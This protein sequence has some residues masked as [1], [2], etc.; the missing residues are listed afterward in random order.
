MRISIPP[1]TSRRFPFYWG[2]ISFTIFA[3][4]TIFVYTTSRIPYPRYPWQGF[5][6]VMV[7]Y[8]F[9]LNGIP[10]IL[11]KPFLKWKQKIAWIISESISQLVLMI[12]V[13]WTCFGVED[14]PQNT[15][16]LSTLYNAG[17]YTVLAI[18]MLVWIIAAVFQLY[19]IKFKYPQRWLI[20][21]VLSSVVAYSF[22]F[23]CLLL[24]VSVPKNSALYFLIAIFMY[25]I[26][27]HPLTGLGLYL[28]G[29]E[30]RKYGEHIE[31]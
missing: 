20:Y 15:L 22:F 26:F 18:A 1:I 23:L 2:L 6:I 7:L 5:L 8:F 31:Q 3:V 11:L 16:S 10:L 30:N 13:F 25:A 12:A 14:Y 21:S 17:V 4:L 27:A 29:M 28:S 24:T 19:I 9:A